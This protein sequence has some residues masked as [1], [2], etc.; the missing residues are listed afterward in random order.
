MTA[1]NEDH[2]QPL[3]TSHA[4]DGVATITLN[5]PA[6]LNALSPPTFARL[7]ELLR[8]AAENPSVTEIV[9]RGA[10]RAFAAGADIDSYD[11]LSREGFRRLI[12]DA[13]AVTDLFAQCP[14]PIVAVVHGF[15]LGGGFELVMACDLVVA[16]TQ[17]RFGLPEARLGLLPGGGG[18]QRLPRLV[19]RLRANELVMTRRILTAEEAYSWGLVNRLC[20]QQRLDQTVAELIGELRGSAPGAL[21]LAKQLI[22]GAEDRDLPAGLTEEAD[23]TSVLIDTRDAREGIAA[24]IQKREPVFGEPQ[25]SP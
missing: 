4:A 24:F 7:G 3:V 17:A 10:G 20:E 25:E 2:M 1:G 15:A 16:T 9:L 22:A 21:A 6:K 23:R 12:D 11:D 19:G 13:R 8:A 18:T 14:K 5:R